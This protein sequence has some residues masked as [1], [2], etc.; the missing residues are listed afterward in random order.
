MTIGESSTTRGRQSLSGVSLQVR[1]L[2]SSGRFKRGPA[3][4]KNEGIALFLFCTRYSGF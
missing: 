1:A 4:Q 2:S 3:F